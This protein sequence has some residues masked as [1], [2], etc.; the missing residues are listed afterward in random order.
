MARLVTLLAAIFAFTSATF[1]MSS[2]ALESRLVF[3]GS[4]VEPTCS[5][6]NADA[7]LQTPHDDRLP[8]RRRCGDATTV[9]DASRPYALVIVRLDTVDTGN[10]PLLHYFTG[11]ANAVG[12]DGAKPKLVVRTYQ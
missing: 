3:S 10:D 9:A 12:E 4:I 11:Y 7:A 8:P 5:T 1:S 6:S 2:S